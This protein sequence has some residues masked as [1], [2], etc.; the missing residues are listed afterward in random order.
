MA[1]CRASTC[2][3]KLAAGRRSPAVRRQQSGATLIDALLPASA[4][5][6]SSF[7]RPTRP[8]GAA[9]LLRGLLHSIEI[10]LGAYGLGLLIG[11]GGAYG[12]LYGGPVVRDLLDVYTTLVR[13]VPELVLILLLYYAGTD[14]INQAAGRRSATSASTSA[15]LSP[16][17]PCSASCRAPIRPR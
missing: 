10:A 1:P 9:T 14:L 6:I 5:G 2:P 4:A 3:C 11:T 12:K 17:S 15:A 16:A 13:A 7:S 8:A